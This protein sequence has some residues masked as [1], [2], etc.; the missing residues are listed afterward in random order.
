MTE[1][2]SLVEDKE[3]LAGEAGPIKALF[4]T[5]SFPRW[6][7]DAAGSFLLRLAVALRSENVRVRVVA[8]TGPGLRAKATIEGIEVE[9]FRYAPRR[10]ET[11]AY[12]GNMASDV[13]NSWRARAAMVGFLAANFMKAGRAKKAFAP[14]IVHAHW[15]FPGGVVSTLLGGRT[16]KVITLHGTDV[17]LAK[18][19]ELAR[20]IL[21]QVL[22]RAGATMAVSSW[23]VDEVEKLEPGTRAIVAPMPADTRLFKPGRT[24]GGRILFVGRLTAQ[25]GVNYLLEALALME[26]R[27]SLDIVGKGPER[28][29][30][31]N[32]AGQLGINDRVTWMGQVTRELLPSLYQRA[33]AL[34]VP[35][36]EEG[37]GLVA[38]EALLCEAPVIAFDSSGLVDVIKHGKTGILVPAGDAKALARAM[39]EMV[40]DS[41]AGRGLGRAGRAQ[42]LEQFGPEVVARRYA[43]IYRQVI[44]DKRIGRAKKRATKK[45]AGEED[46]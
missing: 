43:D 24:R 41:E 25:K 3:G 36:T 22:G 44:E 35:S 28:A 26:E 2:K 17:R 16:P 37:L 1:I 27:V 39:D 31:E 18:K 10:F 33:L 12:T 4:L 45:W 32:L 21:R 6:E 34:V 23:L 42:A 46:A 5:H 40:R 38:V 14:D 30:L 9:R 20:P 8:P 7:G 15:W 11:L 19:I 29:A 13:A